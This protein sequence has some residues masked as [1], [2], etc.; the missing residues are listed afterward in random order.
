M[1]ALLPQP[2]LLGADVVMHIGLAAALSA[3]LMAHIPGR[4]R[5]SAAPTGKNPLQGINAACLGLAVAVRLA[6]AVGR[7]GSLF[8]PHRL[9]QF[10][11]FNG[12]QGPMRSLRHPVLIH[13]REVFYALVITVDLNLTDIAAV[14]QQV[15][16]G[17]HLPQ[18]LT[19]W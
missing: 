18:R 11:Q 2:L 14:A 9:G 17:A 4:H 10:K 7:I 1:V 5:M 6:N 13:L 19:P 8:I 12:N 3:C 16:D 15:V